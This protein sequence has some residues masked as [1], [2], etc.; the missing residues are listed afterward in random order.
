MFT[1]GPRD[2]SRCLKKNKKNSLNC[3]NSIFIKTLLICASIIATIS[4]AK[5]RFSS[6]RMVSMLMCG[7]LL[8]VRSSSDDWYSRR[9]SSRA[10]SSSSPPPIFEF[11]ERAK[12]NGH[13]PVRGPCIT[14]QSMDTLRSRVLSCLR[15]ETCLPRIYARRR[16]DRE[17]CCFVVGEKMA[18]EACVV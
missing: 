12:S 7:L 11:R 6:A 10:A 8:N 15:V 13:A 5:C 4:L 9:A 14:R 17:L 3:E 1:S 16:A 18:I 2:L